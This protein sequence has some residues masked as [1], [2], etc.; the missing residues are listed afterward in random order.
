MN[1]I[2]SLTLNENAGAQTVNLSGISSGG[3]NQTLTVT[4][5][6]S[7]TGLIPNPSVNYA[8]PNATGSLAFT[9]LANASGSSIVTVTVNDGGASN[10]I[11]TKTFTVT[12][13]PVNQPPTLNSINS[14][15]LNENAGAQTVNL[16]G[17]SSGG[18]NQTL[19]VTAVSSNTGLIP[20]PSV[21]Y[22]SPNATG[23]L[24]FTPLANA[25]GS[26]IVT[27]TVNDGGASNNIVTKTFTVTVNSI[28]STNN[29]GPIDSAKP[30]VSI[31]SPT[32]NHQATNGT[33]TATGK[34]KDNVAVTSVHYSLNG[35]SWTTA[36]TTNNWANWT[37]SLKLTP[38][39]NTIQAYAV[40]AVG[41]ISTTNTIRFKYVVLIPLS[42]AINGKGRVSPN[43]NGKLLAVNESYTMTA[44]ASSG[45]AFTNWTGSITTNS[46]TIQVHDG[47]ESV[48]HCE[49]CGCGQTDGEHCLTDFQPSDNQRHLY[50]HGQGQ[51]QRRREIRLLLAQ[52]RHLDQCEHH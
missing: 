21:N 47:D 4:A 14:L 51:R 28:V 17:I 22:A 41:N 16:S 37:A 35:S 49:L 10:N 34:A 45:F 24:A 6:S 20:N 12:V 52:Q 23:S 3:E 1:S 33:F 11:I 50:C 38:G 30:T 2:N 36:V 19:T 25:S 15:T 31:V 44:H 27:V 42:V 40:D 9:P 29:T 5:V 39:T 7:N 18:E 43:Y 46:A 26:S 13:N 48:I 8:S 32:S